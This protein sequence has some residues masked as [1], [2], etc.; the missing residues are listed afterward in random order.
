M[1]IFLVFVRKEFFHIFRDRRTL[2]ILFG[3][4]VIQILLFG[5]AI[6]NEIRN[7]RIAIMDNSRDEY[8]LKLSNKLLSS[9]YF[10]EVLNASSLHE[11]SSSFRKGRIDMAIVFSPQFDYQLHHEGKAS[12]QLIADASDPNTASTLIN[13]ATSIINNDASSHKPGIAPNMQIGIRE[14]M[15]YN[16]DLKSVYMFIPGL[17]TLILM[18][19]SAM[20]TSLTIA[21]EKELGTME[22]LLASPLRPVMIIMG[23]GIPYLLLSAIN[24]TM[25]LLMGMFVFGV[26]LVGNVFLLGAECTLFIITALSLGILISSVSSSQQT[27][28]MLSMVGLLMPTVMLSGY[29][30]PLDS[31]PVFLQVIANLIPAKWFIIIIKNIMLKGA[32]FQ[33][34]W[35]QTLILVAMTSAFIVLSIKNFKIRLN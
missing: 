24:A 10:Q 23:K 32:G 14:K 28:M 4:P 12:I 30:F 21:R 3:M 7:A 16:P 5:F 31:M 11:I 26:P 34:V 13:Y 9:G 25:I 20:M 19:V 27:A 6:T 15:L 35:K 18:L 29:I 8:T 17:M 22:I 1:R 2:L 33:D